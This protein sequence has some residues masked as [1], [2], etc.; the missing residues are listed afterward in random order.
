[1]T[2]NMF[3]NTLLAFIP[4]FVA[5]DVIGVIPIFIGFTLE[6]PD[7]RKRKVILRS[8]ATAGALALA[9]VFLGK[10][11]FRFLGIE[12]YDFMIAGGAVLFCIAILD[13]I[14]AE[15]KRRAPGEELAVVPLGTPLLAGPALLTTS[16]LMVETYGLAA[17]LISVVANILIAGCV[18]AFSGTLMKLMGEAGAKALS[19]VTSL[20]LAAIAVMLIR[21]GIL[22]LLGAARP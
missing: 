18:L 16:L 20:F 12:I 11:I 14:S 1:M 17:T 9:F 13:I 10:A 6:M 22:Q 7:S 3:R 15:K 21:K 5:V 19:K 8:M 4:V 2:E